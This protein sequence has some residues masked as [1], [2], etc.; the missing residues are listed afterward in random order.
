[1]FT[2]CSTSAGRFCA[3]QLARSSAPPLLSSDL[4]ACVPSW[5]RRCKLR[6][7]DGE[8][9][10]RSA[11]RRSGDLVAA[12]GAAQRCRLVP[13]LKPPPPC[14]LPSAALLLGLR[15]VRLRSA[16]AAGLG[17][18]HMPGAAPPPPTAPALLRPGASP[19]GIRCWRL[20]RSPA[21]CASI[22][23]RR[24]RPCSAYSAALSVARRIRRA[25][26]AVA[27]EAAAAAAAGTVS[28][29]PPP[30]PRRPPVQVLAKSAG[31]GECQL[32]MP[33]ASL[34]PDKALCGGPMVC[35]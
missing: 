2:F 3:T 8:C 12:G 11:P 32:P 18:R 26:A 29:P 22:S 27:V 19:R 35:G 9:A 20:S 23:R 31:R 4:P 21:C 33:I 6:A 10:P 15:G 17:A 30:T 14:T 1:M 5:R 7:A 24:C 28:A 25:V 16:A 13:R 34:Q